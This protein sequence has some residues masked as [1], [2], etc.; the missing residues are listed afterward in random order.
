MQK[1]LRTCLC[2]IGDATIISSKQI[3]PTKQPKNLQVELTEEEI[4]SW[5]DDIWCDSDRIELNN[6]LFPLKKKQKCILFISG[7]SCL[8][9]AMNFRSRQLNSMWILSSFGLAWYL[10]KDPICNHINWASEIAVFAYIAIQ[11]SFYYIKGVLMSV[12]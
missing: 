8:Q 11:D 7:N 3:M 1:S 6:W 12:Y 10:A 4:D 9:W 5:L 2:I